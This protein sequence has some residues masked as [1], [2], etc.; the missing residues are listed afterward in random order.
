MIFKE[1]VVWITGAS[2]GIGEALVYEFNKRNAKIII[3]ARRIDE[4]ERVKN[5][6][7]NIENIRII[8]LDLENHDVIEEKANQA[9]SFFGKIDYLINNGGISQ[10]SLVS[11]THL[12]I[13]K[14]IM[15]VNYFG[16]IALTKAVLPNM[17]SRKTGHI[18][19]ISS[20][21]GKIGTALRS[22]YS[23][24][25]H[26]LHGFFDSLR[27]EVWKE[28]IFVTIICPGY[29]KTNV[30]VN[31]ITADGTAQNSMDEN[32]ENGML[33]EILAEKI[34]KAIKNKKEEVNIGGPEMVGIYL[35]R[36]MPRIFSSIIKRRKAV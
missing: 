31:A 17:L 12:N 24:S 6:C 30:S 25:K 9:F 10:R 26:A 4:L 19:V 18:I 22:A 13:D 7:K 2:S 29:V 15:D 34:I 1:K 5:N 28:N 16:T 11:E 14:K 3:S 27:A 20:V 33:P 32:S 35:K 23:A 8:Q 36:C 21:A